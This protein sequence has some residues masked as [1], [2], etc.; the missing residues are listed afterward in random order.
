MD[1]AG[2]PKWEAR[3]E[4]QKNK[5]EKKFA[6]MC[7]A[8]IQKKNRRIIKTFS[9]YKQD[10]FEHDLRTEADSSS[11]RDELLKL[12]Y[13]VMR[14]EQNISSRA[15]GTPRFLR[16]LKTGVLWNILDDFRSVYST[17]LSQMVTKRLILKIMLHVFT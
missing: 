13:Y 8:H 6:Q 11:F 7:P 16:E 10:R 1:G 12:P 3:A 14:I 17:Y 2:N 15:R 4:M 9:Q 5:L